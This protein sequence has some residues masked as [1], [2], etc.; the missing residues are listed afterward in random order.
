MHGSADTVSMDQ[1]YDAIVLG[2]GLKECIISGLL[3][4]GGKKVRIVHV[5][6]GPAENTFTT[7]ML[8]MCRSFTWTVTPTMAESLHPLI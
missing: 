2:T 8:H 3:S 6:C 5:T 7:R 1:E 4:V